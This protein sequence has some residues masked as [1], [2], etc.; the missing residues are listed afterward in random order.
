MTTTTTE[1]SEL[2]DQ[3]RAA[4]IAAFTEKL[5]AEQ[6]EARAAVVEFDAKFETG[7]LRRD[8][9]VQYIEVAHRVRRSL[10]AVLFW[11]DAIAEEQAKG[12]GR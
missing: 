9:G 10:G 1:P 8:D 11:L 2:A 4:T 12:G 7:A 3:I 5:L 6:A